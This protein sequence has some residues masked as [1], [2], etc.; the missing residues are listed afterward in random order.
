MKNTGFLL[1]IDIGSSSVK[2]S[3]VDSQTGV[4]RGSAFSPPSEMHISSPRPGWA[5]QQPS[6]WE[7]HAKTAVGKALQN[8]AIS[9]REVAS[10]G[11]TYQ[12]HGLVCL[13]K[14]GEVLRPSIIWCDSRAVATGNKAMDSLGKEFCLKH[15]L[16]SPGN[17][18]AS[19]LEWVKENEPGIFEKIHSFML[20][21]DWLAFRLTGEKSTTR[22]GLSEGILWDFEKRG[23][24]TDLLDYYG[25]A[26]ELIPPL[27]ETF[28]IQGNLTTSA[29]AEFG[30]SP[31]IPVSY[32]SG[33]Q[34]NNA[35]SLK[36]LNPGDI[37][38]T[39]G[40]S[41]VVYCVTGK[42]AFDKHSRVNTFVHVNDSPSAARNGILLCI[43]GTGI[44]NSW[45]RR[46]AGIKTYEE[47]NAAA[48][49]V[50]PGSESLHFYP[51]G[52]GAER[53]LRNMNP[54][55]SFEKIDFTRH[56]ANHMLRAIQEGIAFS[57]RY[58][59]DIMAGMD[60]R[61]SVIRAGHAN[62][63]LSPVFTQTLSNLASVTIELYNT[64]GATGAALGAGLGSGIYSSADEAFSNL[65][66]IQKTAPDEFQEQVEEAYGNWE[67]QLNK[68][69]EL[70]YGNI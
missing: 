58:G 46:I 34:P 25:I 48:A 54:G 70:T 22:S 39:A 50:L 21:G 8:A 17:F 9:G 15:Y 23:M 12:M 36:A 59:L 35:F 30:L 10:V 55:A 57:F 33:D 61:P 62:L 37:A 29:A 27:C 6:E 64:D 11:I 3:V 38:A 67:K 31:G 44:S 24:A 45:M 47:V 1:G 52:N 42:A 43:N 20:P 66:C 32:R 65:K 7:L 16:N 49:D 68:K 19:K 40:T 60:I 2:A 18:T 69:L 13:D 51:F 14:N 5:E 4:C 41:G 63:F 56:S 26:P 53:M 28:G